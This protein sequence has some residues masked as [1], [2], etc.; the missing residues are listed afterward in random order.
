LGGGTNIDLVRSVYPRS[1]LDWA[2][3]TANRA[4]EERYLQQ[5]RPLIHPDYEASWIVRDGEGELA[6][7]S[8]SFAAQLAALHA[9]MK[10][11]DRYLIEPEL[12]V[13][14]DD[15][16]LVFVWLTMV[17]KG[18]GEEIQASAGTIYVLADGR[19]IAIEAYERRDD[20]LDAAGLDQAEAEA[21]GVEPRRPL[22][23]PTRSA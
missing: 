15:R 20:A 1:G 8:A 6:R 2:A 13:D 23:G 3:L 14:L 10:E 16:V 4:D 12:L 11:F 17:P 21:R 5:V 7:S 18:G 9:V 22:S 19:I